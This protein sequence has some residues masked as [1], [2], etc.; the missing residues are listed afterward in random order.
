VGEELC[1][2][3]A[4]F[5]GATLVDVDNI[6]KLILDSIKGLIYKD[7][8]QVTDLISR[9]RSLAGPY[10]IEIDSPPLTEALDR[11]QEFLYIRVTNPPMKGGLAL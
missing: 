1:L 2:T 3:I 10:R 5:Y 9:R 11:R 8:S 6:V 4:F 7:D